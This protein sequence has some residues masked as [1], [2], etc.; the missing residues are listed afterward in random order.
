MAAWQDRLRDA[1]AFWD[2]A[3]AA[4]DPEHANQAVSNAV[5][6]A[7]AAN[8]A[9]C[10]YL[11][12]RRVTGKSHAEA[13]DVLQEVCRGTRWER[14]AGPRASRLTELIEVK[15]DVQYGRRTLSREDAAR[16]MVQARRFLEWVEAILADS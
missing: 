13:A 4:D 12:G 16:A 15:N 8:D 11:G 9:L 7:I 3:E 6:A 2:L 14:E 10:L 1:G 5:L